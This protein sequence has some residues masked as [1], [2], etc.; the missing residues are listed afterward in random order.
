M[1]AEL[2]KSLN[3]QAIESENL[4]HINPVTGQ[5]FLMA[6]NTLPLKIFKDTCV[7]KVHICKCAYIISVRR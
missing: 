7:D 3:W 5:V 2:V 1:S 6:T 4:S